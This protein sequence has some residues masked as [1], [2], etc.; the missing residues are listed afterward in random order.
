MI[1]MLISTSGCGSRGMLK[2]V[3]HDA[4][5]KLCKAGKGLP[6]N[7]AGSIASRVEGFFRLDLLV[8]FISREK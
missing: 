2:Q 6:E 7:R 1:E 5:Y 3:Q 8:T 4:K